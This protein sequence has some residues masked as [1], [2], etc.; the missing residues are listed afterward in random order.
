MVNAVKAL[1]AT[2]VLRVTTTNPLSGATLTTAP[3]GITFT[4]NKPVVFSTVKAADL[5]FTTVPPGVT[6]SVGTP[7]A[8][9]NPAFPTIITFP[10]SFTTTS[11]SILAN[12]SY[13]YTLASPAGGPV[14]MSQDGKALEAPT[15]GPSS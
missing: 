5:K 13:A 14:V 6:A 8:V 10:F 9:D 2:D 12:G 7:I 3:S 4:F 15:R 11:P 1:N